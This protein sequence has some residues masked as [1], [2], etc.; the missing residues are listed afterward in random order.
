MRKK[1]DE[2]SYSMAENEQ[3][4]ND[5]KNILKYVFSEDVSFSEETF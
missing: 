4:V 5:S 1:T 2:V 3:Y